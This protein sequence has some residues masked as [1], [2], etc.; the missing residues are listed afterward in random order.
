MHQSIIHHFPEFN[1]LMECNEVHLLKY[2]SCALHEHSHLLPRYT[3]LQYN[4]VLK[5]CFMYMITLVA[6]YSAEFMLHQSHRSVYF[7]SLVIQQSYLK[8]LTIEKRQISDLIICQVHPHYPIYSYNL[9]S[10]VLTQ[11]HLLLLL[12]HL[13][14]DT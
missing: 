11:V 13:I 9:L 14:S 7:I 1:P 12:Q 3:P 8:K 10:F 2:C 4:I 5:L 6:S